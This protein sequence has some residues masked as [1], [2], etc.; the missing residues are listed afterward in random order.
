MMSTSNVE[1]LSPQ[2]IRLVSKE[3]AGLV[4]EPPEG[5]RVI[6]NEE[7]VT[8]IQ[9]IIDGPSGT[10]Y[11]GGSFHMKLVLG[12]SFPAEAPKGFFVTKIFHP[13]V[14]S[15]GEICVNALK[16]DWNPHLGIKHVLLVIKCLLINPNPESALNEE[17]G[18]LLLEHYD[19]FCS[20]ARLHTEIHAKPSK[21]KKG[22]QPEDATQSKKPALDATKSQTKRKVDKKKQLKRL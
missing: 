22:V 9:A 13:N 19:D 1:N 8:D 11:A 14:S 10:P 21:I 20:R 15:S 5:V 3:M 6:T 4:T 12:K 16:K 7:D 2:I 17:A 18:K